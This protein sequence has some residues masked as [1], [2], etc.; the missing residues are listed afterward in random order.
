MTDDLHVLKKHLR[1]IDDDVGP[2]VERH[3]DQVQCAKGCSDCCHQT[4][5][6]SDLEGELLRAGLTQ[7][8]PGT[9]RDILDRARRYVPDSK[10]PCPVLG[11][12][13]ACRL[14]DH[15]PR[16]CRKYGI[17]LWHPD[18]PEQVRCCPKNFRD[19]RDLEPDLI[20]EPQARWAEDW[21][22]V[23]SK[24]GQ[25]ATHVATIAEQ[26]MVADEVDR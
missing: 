3:R 16:I 5:R 12:D 8:D 10:A 17:P 18:R 25:R 6:V 7:L 14:Y 23:R 1:R 9:K 26:L 19:L 21:I 22:E 11:A 15:R 13:G 4:F 20:V 2:V 24:L